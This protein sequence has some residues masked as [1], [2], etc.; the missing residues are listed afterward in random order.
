MRAITN[1]PLG[2]TEIYKPSVMLNILGEHL[3]LLLKK[4]KDLPPEAKM[5]LYGKQ[6][7]RTGRKMGHINITTDTLDL[8]LTPLI[9]LDIWDEALLSNML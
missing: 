5:H 4:L 1:M 6:E 8:L 3:P 2:S 7:C 9:K